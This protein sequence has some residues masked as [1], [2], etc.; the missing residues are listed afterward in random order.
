M[1]GLYGEEVKKQLYRNE[2]SKIVWIRKSKACQMK[3]TRRLLGA[4]L[5]SAFLERMYDALKIM[6]TTARETVVVESIT[7]MPEVGLDDIVKGDIGLLGEV[8]LQW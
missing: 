7:S 4:F 3:S 8:V 6:T 2:P 1:S 5:G